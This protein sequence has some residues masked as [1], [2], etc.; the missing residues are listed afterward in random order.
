M[1][2]GKERG[3]R[4]PKIVP[5]AQWE[6]L[7]TVAGDGRR[8]AENALRDRAIIALGFWSGIRSHE[9]VQLDVADA[10]VDPDDPETYGTVH[11]RHGKG[12][13]ERH[14]P[15]GDRGREYLE[16]YL[17]ER[18]EPDPGAGNPLFVS[19]NGGRISTRQVRR[20]WE[21]AGLKLERP[22]DVN[23][24]MARH[25]NATAQVKNAA[26]KNVSLYEVAEN[27]GHAS[28]DTLRLY[29]HLDLESR[30]ETVRDL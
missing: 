9:L 14:A 25:S 19:R 23:P 16:A 27:L 2:R 29:T 26:K 22:L 28:L 17:D 1:R 6:E 24:H 30:R 11:V 15:V 13:K 5:R 18:K 3:R 20:L 10:K 21:A 4:L 7:I 12:D 8:Y